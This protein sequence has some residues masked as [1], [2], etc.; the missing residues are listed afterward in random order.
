MVLVGSFNTVFSGRFTDTPSCIVQGLARWSSLYSVG[1]GG[2][3]LQTDRPTDRPRSTY[4]DCRAREVTMWHANAQLVDE[5]KGKLNNYGFVKSP[6]GAAC[7][8]PAED[9]RA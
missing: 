4:T 6:A 5:E 3:D 1:V 7:C 2:N 9:P 8:A